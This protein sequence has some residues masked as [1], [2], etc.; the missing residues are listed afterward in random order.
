M[1]ISLPVVI[2]VV[3]MI[4]VLLAV[5][6]RRGGRGRAD[7]LGAPRLVLLTPELKREVAALVAAGHKIEAIKL[8]R[9]TMDV[10]LKDAKAMV[11]RIEARP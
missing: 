6:L 7:L 4:V 9:E 10:D 2:A 5:L 3:A 8:V 1:F 11:E